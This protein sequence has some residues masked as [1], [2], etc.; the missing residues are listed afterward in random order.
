MC[1]C[2]DHEEEKF[3][4][5]QHHHHNHDKKYQ[6]IMCNNEAVRLYHG[7]P[8]CEKCRHKFA[9]ELE[10][11]NPEK[12]GSIQKLVD[13][14]KSMLDG[15]HDLYGINPNNENFIDTPKRVARLML[16]LNYGANIQAA[17]DLMTVSFPSDNKYSGMISC[18]NIRVSSL[19]PHHLVVVNYDVAM[20]YVPAAGRCIG[21]SKLPRLAKTLAKS[22]LLQEDYTNKLA[23]MMMSQLK[24]AGCAVLVSGVH[25]CVQAR[26]VE[27]RDVNNVTCELRGTFALNPEL[28]KEWL[29]SIKHSS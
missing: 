18:S 4:E 24:P 19:C 2:C 20:A 6:C 25:N 10:Y 8:I 22:M 1:D 26:G 21:L 17:K 16:E 7:V 12:I 28:K 27:M 3:L 15:L 11:A 5:E 14:V 13:G 23:D 29:F 9:T